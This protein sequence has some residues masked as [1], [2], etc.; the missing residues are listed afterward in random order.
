[1]KMTLKKKQT[2]RLFDA[3]RLDIPLRL[4]Y[5]ADGLPGR[6][7]VFI[8]DKKETFTVSFEEGLE[9]MDVGF[10]TGKGE[11]AASVQS[12]KDGKFI[13]QCRVNPQRSTKTGRYAF[14][15]IELEDGEGKVHRIPG[16]IVA[17]AGYTWSDGVE[18]VLMELL[19]GISLIP[20]EGEG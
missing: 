7:V 16:Q 10:D 15:H 11:P 6:R 4:N 1:M 9:L 14:F 8:S 2:V 20:M 12:C 19:E 17:R 3:F 5:H 18:P 13:R